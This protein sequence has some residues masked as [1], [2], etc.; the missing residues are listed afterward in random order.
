M[1]T[2]FCL[3]LLL[4]LNQASANVFNDRT[5]TTFRKPSGRYV[6][7]STPDRIVSLSRRSISF[8]ADA[9]AQKNHANLERGVQVGAAFVKSKPTK[10]KNQHDKH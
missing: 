7:A 5:P 4:A 6:A 1:I 2:F 9:D 3:T 8:Y 10:K